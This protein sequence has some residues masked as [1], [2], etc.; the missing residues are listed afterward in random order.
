MK[1]LMIVA[2]VF[3][4]LTL[5]GCI[6]PYKTPILVDIGTNETAFM[7]SLVGDTKEEQAKFDSIG[8][9]KEKKIATKQIEI[10][11][12]WVQTGRNG[13][14][15]DTNGL[16]IPSAKLIIVNR[17][18]YSRRWTADESTGSVKANQGLYAESMDSIGVSS[19]FAI[20]AY[21]KE[22]D[23]ATYLYWFPSKE[24]DNKKT[25]DYKDTATPLH[26]VIDE[27]VFTAVQSV[28]TSV[29]NKYN[30]N[31]LRNKKDEITVKIREE[32][33]PKFK[34]MGITIDTTMGLIGGLKYENNAIQSAIDNV[35][36]AQT[37]KE[38]NIAK[39]EAQQIENNRIK[40]VADTTLY[41]AKRFAE[42]QEAQ[43]E[44]IG[45][46]IARVKAQALMVAAEKW[47]GKTPSQILPQGSSF[48]FGLD[49]NK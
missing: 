12:R 33:I 8:A 16:W 19:G 31:E 40:S 35:F 30:L 4:S 36:I 3:I 17:T 45:L 20:T 11:Q 39:N 34:S 38:G 42:A 13:W 28:Y 27:Q 2:V 41:E 49:S 1:R 37:T 24:V 48:L 15:G 6:K 14:G 18:P 25:E 7:V 10:P 44:K 26:K 47:D 9:I 43:K 5:V 29:C 21:I 32:I 46:E 23:A 22:E